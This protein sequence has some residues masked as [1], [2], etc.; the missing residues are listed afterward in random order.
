MI[1]TI[2]TEK[3][4]TNINRKSRGKKQ[5]FFFYFL[6]L[7]VFSGSGFSGFSGSVFSVSVFSGCLVSVFTGDFS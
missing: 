4:T 2:N 5:N 3:I 7:S 6:S 1:K